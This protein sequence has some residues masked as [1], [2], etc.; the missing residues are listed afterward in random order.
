M[1]I[2]RLSNILTVERRT[3]GTDAAGERADTWQ[4]I[5]KVW[6]RIVPISGRERS[7]AL[8]RGIDAAVSHAITVRAGH[9]IRVDDRLVGTDGKIYDVSGITGDM[10]GD[11]WEIRI[12]ATERIDP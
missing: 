12:D 1:R 5:G 8:S 11:D 3:D 7:D 9:P 2:G 6:A 10:S 4:P